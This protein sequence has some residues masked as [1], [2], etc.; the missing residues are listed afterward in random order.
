MSDLYKE[1]LADAA[2][3]RE[4]AEQDARSAILER[5]NPYIKQMIAKEASN[6]FLLEQEDMA[7]EASAPD[8]SMAPPDAMAPSEMPITP[9]GGSD[10][11]NVPMPSG[12]DGKITLNFDDLFASEG[13]AD[14][15]NPA[16]MSQASSMEVATPTPAIEAAPEMP[17]PSA[18]VEAPAAAPAAEAAPAEAGPTPAPET[19]GA[20]AEEE[21]PVPPAPLAEVKTAKQF[22]R[23]LAEMAVKID[24][25]YSTKVS[26]LT[27]DAYKTKLFSLLEQL[28][29]LAANKVISPKQAQ[30]NENRLEFLFLHLK[31][32]NLN[33][34]YNKQKDKDKTMT[35]LKEFAAKLF[36]SADAERLGQDSQSTG[37]TG[38]PV[39]KT[40]T[41]HAMKASG[42]H[43]D[44]FGGGSKTTEKLAAAGSVDADELE[45]LEG[46]EGAWEQALLEE[47]EAALRDELDAHEEPEAGEVPAAVTDSG[48]FEI[49]EAA[50]KEAVAKIRK[51]AASKKATSK[52]AIK[53]AARKK[54]LEMMDDG[55]KEDLVLS[56][57]LPS[58][59]EEQLADEDLD[60]DLMFSGEEEEGMEA[61]EEEMGDEEVVVDLDMSSAGEEGEELGS[62]E[63]E[64]L[65]TDEEGEEEMKEMA[66]KP[67]M[68]SR[69]VRKALL[70]SRTREVKARRL[71]EAKRAETATLKKEM[72]ETNLFLSKLVYLNKF[73]VREDL[74]RKVKQQIVEHLDRASTITEAKEIYGKIVKKLDEAAAAHTAPVVGSASKPTT[75]G[76][77]RLNESV[78]RAA[79]SN[80]SEPVIGT[81][82]KWQILANI[83]R[84][85]D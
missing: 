7:P 18:P 75:A 63:E 47:V 64:M 16:D 80:G 55:M 79:S 51:E 56:V 12:T 85:N 43:A 1:A 14:I 72:A 36:E 3:I 68:E 81:F 24:R 27:Q 46:E 38:L 48:Y 5:I 50:L 22:E 77:A 17:A 74:S 34:S 9:A 69:R 10:V 42:V 25:M 31:E 2:K 67:M 57:E 20:A 84:N 71:A 28:D 23:L 58:E 60:V 35:T 45:G 11:V 59:V 8:A 65:L 39:H 44:L 49:S 82:E 13:V 4:I 54:L 78:T 53:E 61:G 26:A 70:E 21:A 62:E 32:A 33:N 40:A 6:S 37:E 15:V 66:M 52:S 83:K 19:A 29:S 76:S 41:A 73:L 30:L